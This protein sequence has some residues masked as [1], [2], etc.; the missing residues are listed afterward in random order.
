MCS[1]TATASLYRLL[2]PPPP[3]QLSCSCASL[4]QTVKISSSF[5]IFAPQISRNRKPFLSFFPEFLNE[6]ADFSSSFL[7]PPLAQSEL[8]EMSQPIS[9]GIQREQSHY[10]L[11]RRR[12][13]EGFILMTVMRVC[14]RAVCTCFSFFPNIFFLFQQWA[15]SCQRG[16]LICGFGFLSVMIIIR[17][18]LHLH[19]HLSVLL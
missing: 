17:S 11:M 13:I 9:S 15:W 8:L 5:C 19:L 16:K 10:R 6:N 1:S 18:H 4:C 3:L 12:G 7:R 14:K 2:P